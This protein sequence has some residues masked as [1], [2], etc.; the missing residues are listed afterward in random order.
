MEEEAKYQISSLMNEGILEIV[1]AGELPKD[2]IEE[3]QLK[4]AGIIS[5]S[6]ARN[7][8]VD[9]RELGEPRMGIMENYFAVRSTPVQ[10]LRVNVAVVD[11]PKHKEMGEFLETTAYNVNRSLK[12]FTDIDAAR[13]WL[14]GK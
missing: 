3:A 1:I 9:R 8:P 14:A 5:E 12:F 10:G 2:D 11:L 6:G 4:I 7:V 13:A